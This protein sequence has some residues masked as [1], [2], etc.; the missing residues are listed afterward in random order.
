MTDRRSTLRAAL[1]A[2]AV[3]AA[4]ALVTLPLGQVGS[5]ASAAGECVTQTTNAFLVPVLPW[6]WLPAAVASGVATWT[7][8][9]HRSLRAARVHP[10]QRPSRSFE[11]KGL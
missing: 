3:A 1:L 7:I 2:V 8:S 4:V 10:R 11:R 6:L 9:R 5:C